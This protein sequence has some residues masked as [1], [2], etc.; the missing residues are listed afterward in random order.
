ML[1]RVPPR[2]PE[3]AAGG[4]QVQ[5]GVWPVELNS[6]SSLGAMAQD[7]SILGETA[8]WRAAWTLA[9][10]AGAVD[11]IGLSAFNRYSAHMSGTS[12]TLA[13]AATTGDVAVSV[14]C[15]VALASFVAGALASG[16]VMAWEA[17]WDARG[18]ARGLLIGE[19][20]LLALASLPLL[21]LAAGRPH[22]AL[23]LAL[24]AAA[25]GLQNR[26][27]VILAS[28]SARTTHVTG[29]LTDLGY[30]LGRLALQTPASRE[31]RA[32]DRTR[33]GRLLVLFGAF[34][35][36]GVTGRIAFLV[37]GA[38]AIALFGILPAAT[39]VLIVRRR[40]AY[41]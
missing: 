23:A 2:M 33:A 13:G 29:T 17:D 5:S 35:L 8:A 15:G 34:L 18:R 32:D 41:G 25:M 9:F 19:A 10:T 16:V 21:Q 24:M 20:G 40:S 6:G 30:R 4:L 37:L 36:G 7:D 38:A 11:S 22:P 3:C 31:T 39:A 28:G 26:T 1:N 27:G 14:I 12:S